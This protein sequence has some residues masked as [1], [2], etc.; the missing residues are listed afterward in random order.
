MAV[1]F[2]IY[3]AFLKRQME[4]VSPVNFTADTIKLSLHSS[5]YSPSIDNHDFFNDVASEV[6]GT[7]Y[8]A[9]GKNVSAIAISQDNTLDRIVVS[10][11]AN[12]TWA[13]SSII[14]RYG[15]MRKYNAAASASPLIGYLD[16]GEN[17]Q[18]D[19]D[20]FI[21]DWDDTNGFLTMSAS[22]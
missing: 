12:P 22:I 7:G 17:K 2:Q 20:N 4:G 1:T 16:F 14:A 8:A 18:S 15:V 10:A 3:N 9:G 19:G 6:T 11:S 5:G 21:V 13:S